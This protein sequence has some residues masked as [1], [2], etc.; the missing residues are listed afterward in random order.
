MAIFHLSAKIINRAQ[1]RS[2]TGAA[3]Y[4]AG[5]KIA[6]PRTGLT[7]DYRRRKHV[8]F[9]E[10]LC[11]PGAPQWAKN[12]TLLWQ[13]VEAAEVR[14][15]AQLCREIEIALPHELSR[16]AQITLLKHY[17]RRCYVSKGII[18]DVCIHDNE[19]NNHAHVL[20]TTRDISPDGF[21]KKNRRW[22][23]K[24]LLHWWRESWTRSVNATLDRYELEERVDHR[25]L[26]AQAASKIFKEV[27][28]TKEEES[29]G[30]TGAP[31]EDNSP[32]KHWDSGILLPEFMIP[33]PEIMPD[34]QFL[35]DSCMQYFKEMFLRL[36]PAQA[37]SI[38]RDEETGGPGYIVKVGDDVKLT[39]RPDRITASTGS[40]A[41]IAAMVKLILD[42]E[43][44][45]VHLRGSDE[46]KKAAYEA[47]IEAGFEPHE[48]TGYEPIEIPP[49]ELRLL[50][51]PRPGGRR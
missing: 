12:R 30:V 43:W 2:A 17:L 39:V 48:I 24:E 40:P 44:T 32:P 26:A 33:L 18:C 42:M 38:Q 3:A 20:M 35:D 45:G 6:D 1:G 16:E 14:K 51:R 41:E 7:F 22:N 13:A 8:A 10:I 27:T 21:Q 15:D 25:S 28:M 47:L 49:P 4:R 36:F 37:V 9:K 34:E 31:M 29:H 46:F 50:P 19:N 23:D 11:P 5:E